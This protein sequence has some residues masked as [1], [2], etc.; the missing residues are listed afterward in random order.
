M[1]KKVK[2]AT[3]STYNKWRVASYSLK[4][5]TYLL[6]LAPEA[7]MLGLKWEEYTTKSNSW[8]LGLGFSS[9]LLTVIVTI[10]GI[11]KRDK[12]ITKKVSSLFYLAILMAMWAVVLM[13]LA[14]IAYSLGY[15]FLFTSLGVCGGGICDQINKSKVSPEVTWYRE[16]IKEVGLDNK[17]NKRK[18]KREKARLE[19]EREAKENG[20]TI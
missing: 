10:V 2:S 13:F 8:S 9:L 4:S 14:K 16:M 7:T 15:M 11:A 20:T 3:K 1:A 17:E 12:F 18:L 19:A 5:L 6:P